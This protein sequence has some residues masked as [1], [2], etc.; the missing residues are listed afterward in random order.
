MDPSTV[1]ANQQIDLAASQITKCPKPF[2]IES[3]MSTNNSKS[4]DPD[5]VA[6]GEKVPNF[7]I[8]SALYFPSNVSMAAAA[9]I[10]NPWFHF[11]Q[12]HQQHYQQK[13]T[14]N[15]FEMTQFNAINST[16]GIAKEKVADI[17]GN[18]M[19]PADTRTT[20]PPSND[21]RQ[22]SLYFSGKNPELRLN[23]MISCATNGYY[24]QLNNYGNFLAH[25]GDSLEQCKNRTKNSDDN[26]TD[27]SDKDKCSNLVS[28]YNSNIRSDDSGPDENLDDELDSDCNSEI[29]LNMSA[30]ADNTMQ[31]IVIQSKIENEYNFSNSW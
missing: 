15:I 2:S 20:F 8:A 30:D 26:Q 14:E 1:E 9:S 11:M 13:L 29:S 18:H 7:G 12:Q 19:S 27:F 6:K 5:A 10:Y 17:F 24:K 22:E 23:D 16:N 28:E 4:P 3:I 21:E 31:G 25:Y